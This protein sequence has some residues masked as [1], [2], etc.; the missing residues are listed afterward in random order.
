MGKIVI[1]LLII[2]GSAALILALMVFFGLG[3]HRP[4]RFIQN[5]EE[6]EYGASHPFIE[7]HSIKD[8]LAV[9]VVGEGKP[10]LLFPYPHSHATIPMAQDSLADALAAQG[11]TVISFDVPGAFRSTR[12]PTGSMDE[13]IT[14]ADE[15]LDRLGINGPI[16]VV[17]HSMSG[18]SALA[19]AVERPERTHRLVLVGAVSGFPAAA[20]WG[21]PFSALTIFDRE[22]WQIIV[23]GMRAN[24]GRADLAQHKQLANLMSEISFHKKELFT[25]QVIDA[26]D[27]QKGV[28]VRT[29]WSRNMYTRLD[30]A[31]RMSEISAPTLI[32]VG[33][34]DPEAPLACSEEIAAA[35][36][37][38]ELVIFDESGHYP[39]IEERDRFGE[40]IESF[41]GQE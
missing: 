31:G 34:H 16:D 8:G 1:T 13:L 36:P 18:F 41:L 3:Y 10:V 14:S 39:F 24:A 26:D 15:A 19:Y 20:R 22:Y 30:Y 23:W 2:M 29:I 33:R 7:P 4:P 12:T 5:F 40:L 28:P 6:E 21:L 17:G 11:R 9:Y 37:G 32:L 35:I 38:A 25:P 27:N